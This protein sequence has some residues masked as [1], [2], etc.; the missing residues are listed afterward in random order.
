MFQRIL[1]VW[2]GSRPARRALDVGIDLARRYEAEVVAVSIAHSPG[3]A[4]TG[5]DRLESVE[6]ARLYLTDT[7]GRVRDRADRIGVPLEQVV[8]EGDHPAE[9]LLAY[10]HDH[11]FDLIVAGHH[12]GTRSGRLLLHGLT[13]RLVAAGTIPVLVVAE[14]NG[15]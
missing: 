10:A 12:R 6:A 4:E 7:F 14:T 5:A 1:I 15:D 3:H 8:I 11:G 2:D 9:H 13:E